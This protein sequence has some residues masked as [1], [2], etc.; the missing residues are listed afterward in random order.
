MENHNDTHEKVI[1]GCVMSVVWL[2]LQQ[3]IKIFHGSDAAK[4]QKICETCPGLF[5]TI[6]HGNGVVSKDAIHHQR[7]NTKLF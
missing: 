4:L 7:Y 2:D 5:A 6:T 1:S 3:Y